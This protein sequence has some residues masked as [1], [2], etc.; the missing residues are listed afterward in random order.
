MSQGCNGVKGCDKKARQYNPQPEQVHPI[1]CTAMKDAQDSLL[2]RH[3]A[4]SVWLV[5][6]LHLDRFGRIDVRGWQLFNLITEFR[7]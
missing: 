7:P 1:A 4:D 3:R 5:A 6:L 2:K